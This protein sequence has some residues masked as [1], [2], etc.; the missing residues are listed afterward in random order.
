M[1]LWAFLE[2]PLLGRGVTGLASLV[3][4]P[5]GGDGGVLGQLYDLYC[6]GFIVG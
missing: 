1:A 5:G 2:V 4:P 6:W 3:A